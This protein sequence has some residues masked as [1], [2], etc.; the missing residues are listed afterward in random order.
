MKL[1]GVLHSPPEYLDFVCQCIND[2][3][4]RGESPRSMMVELPANWDEI[5]ESVKSRLDRN[6]SLY[7][8]SL[9]AEAYKHR[10]TEIIYGDLNNA[11]DLRRE[12][13]MIQRIIEAKPEITVV[14]RNHAEVIKR[15]FPQV[16]Y[17][18]F[19]DKIDPYYHSL[20]SFPKGLANKV[21]DLQTMQMNFLADLT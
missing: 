4:R 1:F 19:E 9:L 13:L 12:T 14:G 10:G 6:S 20:F 15:R 16:Y 8:F 7:F 2:F 18:A 21:I 17:V 11:S 3:Y 5:P